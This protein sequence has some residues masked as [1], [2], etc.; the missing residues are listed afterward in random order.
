MPCEVY[1]WLLIILSSQSCA[2][3]IFLLTQ[4]CVISALCGVYVKLVLTCMALSG[5]ICAEVSSVTH[6]CW[7]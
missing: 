6:Y 4:V 5:A 7:Q 1:A 2:D 3:I